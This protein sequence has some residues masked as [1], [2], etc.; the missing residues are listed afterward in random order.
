M[1]WPPQSLESVAACPI[2]D[3]TG[4]R[5]LHQGL[6]DDT[7]FTAPGRWT[8]QQCTACGSGYLDPRPTPES[9]GKAYA[10]YYT[11]GGQS[12]APA[13]RLKAAV[14]RALQ[15]LSETYSASLADAQGPA[16][17]LG[18]RLR[19][20]LVKALP[21]CREVI[22]SRYRHLRQPR[23]G[24]DRLLDL[25]CG[26]GDFLERAQLLGWRAEGV[27]FDP[28]AV[29]VAQGRGLK[30]VVGSVDSYAAAR[31]AFD[32]ITCCHVI[33]HVYDPRELLAAIHRILKPGGQLWI[34]TPNIASAG[35]RLFGRA[36]RGLEAPRHLA[37]F[38]HHALVRM[39]RATG[40]AI[41][42]RTPWNIQ[43]IRYMF[44]AS[45]AIASGGDPHNTR[46]HVLPNWRQ[47]RGLLLEAL[48]VERREFVCLRATK[49]PE[50]EPPGRG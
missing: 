24:A 28:K 45:E 7:F 41:T 35:H 39:V 37:I 21:P 4:R 38:D 47:V 22:D 46:T 10:E 32:V 33:E 31:D 43:H 27:D 30:A 26:A 3:S 18:T 49:L 44:A 17:S 29:A 5:L 50:R 11:H 20:A 36:W 19:V 12:R 25:G 6:V 9:I 8:L 15:S 2:C 48:R 34:E 42:H 13:S 40:F 23:P 14:K 1:P 16:R